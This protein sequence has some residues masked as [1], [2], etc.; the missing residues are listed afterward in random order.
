MAQN[1]YQLQQELGRGAF[2]VTYLGYDTQTGRQVAVKTINIAQSA[3]KGLNIQEIRNEIETLIQLSSAPNCSPYIVCYYESFTGNLNGQDTFF[4]VSEF[5][6]GLNLTKYMAQQVG[7]FPV[8]QLWT[9]YH[10]LITGL[11]HMH[12]MGYAHRDI[13]PDNIMYDSV[14][15]TF[16]YIDFGTACKMSC[17]PGV[18]SILWAPP[19]RFVNPPA[20]LE[21]AQKHDVWSLGIIFYQLANR[22]FPFSTQVNVQQFAQQLKNPFPLS[23]YTASTNPRYLNSTINYI[24]DSMLTKNW[25]ERPTAAKIKQY[26]DEENAGCQF[27]GQIINRGQLLQM[28]A[29]AGRSL[30]SNEQNAYLGALCTVFNSEINQ[31]HAVPQPL[32]FSGGA[33]HNFAQLSQ[34]IY[35]AGQPLYSP[36]GQFGSTGSIQVTQPLFPVTQPLSGQQVSQ[37]M[38]SPGQKSPFQQSPGQQLPF[39]QFQFQQPIQLHL[40]ANYQTLP[41]QPIGLPAFPPNLFQTI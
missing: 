27:Q 24:V 9:I 29:Q 1:R 23:N 39:Q 12:R 15:Q 21:A 17:V 4:I 28:Y 3:A 41:I 37:Y 16:K 25:T 7:P 20:G 31:A 32:A 10:Q 5:I 8:D 11:E 13:K 22:Q 33:N 26:M 35:Q 19:E 6:Q 38:L 36:I 34:P 40:P 2:G 14:T 18:L 30:S